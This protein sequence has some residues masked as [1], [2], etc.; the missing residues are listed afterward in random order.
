MRTGDARSHWF[1]SN[2]GHGRPSILRL[3]DR[4][5][6][7]GG[8]GGE[9]AG[10]RLGSVPRPIRSFAGRDRAGRGFAGLAAGRAQT[11]GRLCGEH[12]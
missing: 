12:S 2:H 1:A 6:A 4:W 5:L 7:A 8:A 10:R 3:R 11:S 9:L